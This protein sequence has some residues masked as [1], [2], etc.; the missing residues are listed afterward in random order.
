MSTFTGTQCAFQPITLVIIASLYCTIWHHG[1]L[2]TVWRYAL[3]SPLQRTNVL[4]S[5]RQQNLIQT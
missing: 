2:I 5:P 4:R 3:Q 1:G